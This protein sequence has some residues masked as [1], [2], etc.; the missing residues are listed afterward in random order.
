MPSVT[1]AR[2]F[3][4]CLQTQFAQDEPPFEFHVYP[5]MYDKQDWI[6]EFSVVVD[7]YLLTAR[8]VGRTPD[9]AIQHCYT[10]FAQYSGLA[11]FHR[12]LQKTQPA[13]HPSIY[14]SFHRDKL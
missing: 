6:A 13:F 7:G 3:L 5:D 11:C 10:Y 9:Q 1:N 12:F 4:R 2:E 8:T 14:H